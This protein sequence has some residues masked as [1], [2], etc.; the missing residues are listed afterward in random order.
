MDTNGDYEIRSH[1]PS[2]MFGVT[3]GYP[4]QDIKTGSGKDAVGAYQEITFRWKTPA[5]FSAGIRRYDDKPVELAR[6]E[7]MGR[8]LLGSTVVLLFPRGTAEFVPGFVAAK[9]VRLGEAMAVAA[10][11]G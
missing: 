6:G 9:P 5:E 2:W 7:E 8:F 11:A 10:A 1:V 3:V 4:L